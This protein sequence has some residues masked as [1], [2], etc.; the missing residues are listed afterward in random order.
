M[1]F[2]ANSRAKSSILRRKKILENLNANR[3]TLSLYKIC[4]GPE[5]P[6][7]I[8]GYGSGKEAKRK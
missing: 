6:L 7:P 4:G 1:I 5:P 2:I 8:A 3:S